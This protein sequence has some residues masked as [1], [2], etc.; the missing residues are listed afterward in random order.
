MK[1]TYLCGIITAAVS[2]S[3][4]LAGTLQAVPTN[5]DFSSGLDSWTV[6]SGTVTDGGGYAFFEENSSFYSSLINEQPFT[7]PAGAFELSFELSMGYEG[8]PPNSDTFTVSL[9]DETLNPLISYNPSVTWFYSLEPGFEP[10]T[11]ATWGDIGDD[12][13][14]VTLNVSSFAGTNVL[15]AFDFISEADDVTT[16]VKLDNVNVLAIPAP[17]ALLLGFIGTGLVSL[18]RRSGKLR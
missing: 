12:W 16:T 7:L 4:V 17:A 18:L 1:K 14:R 6:E 10:V 3:L 9:L 15:L 2:I 5:G 8:G 11:V 13:M